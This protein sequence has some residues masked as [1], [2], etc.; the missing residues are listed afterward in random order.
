MSCRTK[1]RRP[2]HKANQ[3]RADGA[4]SPLCA[5]EPRPIDMTVEAWTLTDRFV[6]CAKCKEIIKAAVP[7]Q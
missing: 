5:P 1:S 7:A 3:V 6:T 4:M 2:V